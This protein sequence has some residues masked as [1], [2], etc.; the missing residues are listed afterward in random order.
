MEDRLPCGCR[1]CDGPERQAELARRDAELIQNR[2]RFLSGVLDPTGS[3]ALREVRPQRGWD[4][5]AVERAA[6][7]AKRAALEAACAASEICDCRS[8][9]ISE[10]VI[11]TG[12]CRYRRIGEATRDR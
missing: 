11:A 5:K 9:V 4:L 7:V 1:Q 2:A 6:E 3:L 12:Y 10:H 8:G